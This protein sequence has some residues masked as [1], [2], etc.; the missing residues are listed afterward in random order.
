MTVSAKGCFIGPRALKGAVRKTSLRAQLGW[1]KE[2]SVP[3]RRDL[4]Q[5]YSGAL[6]EQKARGTDT[7]AL[8]QG[9]KKIF[10]WPSERR[11]DG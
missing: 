10:D 4:G 3:I 6:D 5:A 8:R 7:V 9:V 11:P 2:M 1:I